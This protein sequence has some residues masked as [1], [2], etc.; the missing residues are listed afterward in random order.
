[1]NPPAVDVIVCTY[2]RPNEL[3]KT[4]EALLDNLLYSGP[5]H[6]T[7]AD[8]SSDPANMRKVKASAIFKQLKPTI[9]STEQNSGWAA[10]NNN[11]LRR[12]DRPYVFFTEDDYILGQ[13]LDLAAGVALLE[14]KPDVGMLRYRGTAGSHIIYHQFEADISA[15]Y[16]SPYTD[17]PG[18]ESKEYQDGFGLPGRIAYLQLD[19]GSPDLYLYSNGPHLKRRDFHAFYGLYPEG[20]KLGETEEQYA[21][22]VKDGMKRDKAPAVAIL[23]DWVAMR[24][25]HIGQ[26]YQHTADDK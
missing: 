7:I 24:F 22:I 23:P 12:T 13:R 11:A 26:S 14:A 20:L 10:N 4:L 6:F 3:K 1:M 15:H 9:I 21:H 5:L 8:D 16:A 25:D 18:E 17:Y 19:S 2:N